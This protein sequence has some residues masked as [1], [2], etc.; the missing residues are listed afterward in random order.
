MSE[1][2]PNAQFILSLLLIITITVT[3][4]LFLRKFA[5]DYKN[6][7]LWSTVI[8]WIFALVIFWGY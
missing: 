5:V 2:F 6:L 3:L 1:S 4:G 7:L 8:S